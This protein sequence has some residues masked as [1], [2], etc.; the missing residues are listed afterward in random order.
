M[1][2][3]H[4]KVF[5]RLKRIATESKYQRTL[6]VNYR[7]EDIF[8]VSFPKSGNTWLRFLIA[9][10]I[11]VH[12]NIQRQVN[13]FTIQDIIP[14]VNFSQN[15]T[16]PGIF[17]RSDLPR[18]IKSHSAY[19][20]YYNRVI[21]IVRDPRDVLISFYYYTKER[22]LI[23]DSWTISEFIR[24]RKYGAQAWLEH[25]RSWYLTFK[26]GQTIKI[27]KYEDFLQEPEATL[28]S[29]MN[30]LGIIMT[31]KSLEEAIE[32]SSI[33]NMKQSEIEHLSTYIIQHQKTPFVRQGKA[34]KGK[35]LSKTDRKFIENETRAIA[36]KIGYQY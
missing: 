21:L 12:Y 4:Q 35:I 8:L 34:I 3:I 7:M 2:S 31:R 27:F 6:P 36:Q 30:L 1:I 13:F 15:I 11:K 9:N 14:D 32:L 26:N 5:N 23:P 29:L 25:T 22:N 20:P 17:G 18:I 33:E 10:A 19:N 24:E 28:S 16:S